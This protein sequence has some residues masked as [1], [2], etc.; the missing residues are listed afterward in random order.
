MSFEVGRLPG[1][2]GS[3]T[4]NTTKNKTKPGL[5]FLTIRVLQLY[6]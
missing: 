6:Y 5:R 1:G 3:M 4:K 2:E